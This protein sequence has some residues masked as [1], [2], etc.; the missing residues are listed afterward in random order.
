MSQ[1]NQVKIDKEID[2]S[3]TDNL[4]EVRKSNDIIK[5]KAKRGRPAKSKINNQD[6]I[7]SQAS[8]DEEI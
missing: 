3:S 8:T 1:N 6:D 7:K 5:P 4:E 2:V